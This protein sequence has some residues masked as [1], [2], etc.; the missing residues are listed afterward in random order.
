MGRPFPTLNLFKLGIRE[1]HAL[2]YV[3]FKAEDG[4][5]TH[6]KV[7]DLMDEH[8]L[9]NITIKV[10]EAMNLA[11]PTMKSKKKARKKPGK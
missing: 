1:W 3:I 8:G 10:L 5:L 2:L 6:D 9:D 7:Y 11:W 4:E